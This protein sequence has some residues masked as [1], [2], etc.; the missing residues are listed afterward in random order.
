MADTTE[1]KTSDV[2]KVMIASRQ[3]PVKIT[4]S[5]QAPIKTAPSN[6]KPSQSTTQTNTE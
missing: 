2:G 5:R 6:P 3:A 4:E 1:K